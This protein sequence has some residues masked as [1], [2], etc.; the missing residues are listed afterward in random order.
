MSRLFKKMPESE[1]KTIRYEIRLSQKEDEDI[2]TSAL[3]RNLSVAEFM[4]RAAQGRRAD[5]NFETEI[6]LSLRKV[7]Q[8]IRRLHTTFVAQGIP[9]PKEELEVLLDEALS[10]MLRISK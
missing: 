7:V 8:S 6:V 9:I 2:R 3:I 4:R 1:R 5:I 10:A